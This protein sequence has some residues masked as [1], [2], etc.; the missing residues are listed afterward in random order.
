MKERI[1]IYC[2]VSSA[3]QARFGFSLNDQERRIKTYLQAMKE[4]D[5]YV[6]EVYREEGV[7]A[8]STKR[9]ELQK[10]LKKV[11]QKEVNQIYILTLSRLTR[12]VSDLCS[13]IELFNSNDVEFTSLTEQI[14]TKSAHGR[15]FVYLLGCLAQLEREEISERSRRGLEESALEGNYPIGNKPPIGYIRKNKKLIIDDE[16]A[17]VVK[18]IFNKIAFEDFSVFLLSVYLNQKNVCEGGWT[19][20]KIYKIIHN[21]IYYGTLNF[22]NLHLENH[23]P[24][25]VDKELWD[26]ANSKIRGYT[27][28]TPNKYIF[29]GYIYCSKCGKLLVGRSTTKKKTGVR[30]LYYYCSGCGKIISEIKLMKMI[31]PKLSRQMRINEYDKYIRSLAAN[32]K[33][34][35]SVF[36]KLTF[37][38]ME[39]NIEEDFYCVE[40]EKHQKEWSEIME[41]ITIAY[42][43]VQM[44][45]FRKARYGE[46]RH[47]LANNVDQI[48]INLETKRLKVIWK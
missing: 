47:F 28:A 44:I 13:L 29:K 38:K 10:L 33:R 19:A 32:H 7:S 27:H 3:E 22:G 31:T 36:S 39:G 4:P 8:K 12:N 14:D 35:A 15:F 48:K 17:E 40:M 5:T 46:Q 18:D 23:S 24:A 6:T 37:A 2:R 20:N 9:P 1:A 16:R 25:I 41:N 21:P 30:Y 34:F 26:Q 45:S 43:K 42:K 11:S